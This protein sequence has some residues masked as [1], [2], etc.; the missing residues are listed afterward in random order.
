MIE[1]LAQEAAQHWGG[2]SPRLIRNRENAVFEITLPTGPAALRLH[3]MGYQSDA[4][5]WSELWWC[6]ALAAE[7]VAVPAALPNLRGDLLVTLSNGRKASVISWVKGE[8]LGIAGEPFDL[9]LPV[10]L[11]RHRALGRLV[12][13]FHAATAR[14]TLPEAFTRPRWD[15]LGLVGEAPFWSRFWEHPEATPDQRATLIRARAFLRERLTDHATTAPIVPIHADVLRENVL[16]NDH[17]LSL[18]DFDDS[19]WGFALYDLG[20]VLSQNLYEP[21]Y[22]EILEAL[23]EGYGTSDRAMVEIFTLARTCA[24]VGWTIPRLAPG[25]PVHP[26]HL[27]RA[28]M[29]AETMF[30]QYG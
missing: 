9:P 17:S 25:D 7:G 2:Q 8:A 14:L 11:D 1:T 13:E 5:I 21:A 27:A 29:W 26:R 10:L 23:M 20:T 3:R 19:G 12:A 22:P 6:A 30:A 15:I 4:A 28:C 16:V 18:I 24:S